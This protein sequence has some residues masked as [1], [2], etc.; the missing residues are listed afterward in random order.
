[1][2]VN[3][4]I[5][6]LL[7]ALALAIEIFRRDPLNLVIPLAGMHFMFYFF[8]FF[9]YT[10]D[11]PSLDYQLSLY[12]G[13]AIERSEALYY[14]L[15][16]STLF[17]VFLAASL[18]T[19]KRPLNQMYQTKISNI[20]AK[21]ILLTIL[22]VLLIAAAYAKFNGSLLL[23]FTP[24]RK[25][26]ELSGYHR[27]LLVILP[28]IIAFLHLYQKR[29]FLGFVA[30]TVLML[31]VLS[32]LGQRREIVV[33]I[34]FAAMVNYKH[35]LNTRKIVLRFYTMVSA[36]VFVAV[37][38]SWYAR[39]YS[40]Q[41]LRGGFEVNPLTIRSPVELIFGS[42]TTGFESIFLQLRHW[43]LGNIEFAHSFLMLIS[44][45]IPRAIW[46]DKIMSIPQ[47]IKLHE[48]DIGNISSFFLNEFT[49]SFGIALSYL[50]VIVFAWLLQKI[51]SLRSRRPL[52]DLI[53]IFAF[54]NSILLF[55]NGWS[56][57]LITACLFTVITYLTIV[58]RFRF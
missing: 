16:M 10:S 39:A 1:M 57:F 54:A 22:L 33:F 37:P 18:F 42:S 2:I 19:F 3:L 11:F 25:P 30:F 15:H 5:L 12:F 46:P 27:K 13:L 21:K 52:S 26:L 32:I 51:N 9:D 41:L 38:V 23:F 36:A 28:M 56:D 58:W 47:T 29:S 14:L 31:P 7:L 50:A 35:L 45:P 8:P 49:F 34:L 6:T 4:S 24:A 17:L 48:Q 44:A 20:A 53:F 43:E 55:K 40:T